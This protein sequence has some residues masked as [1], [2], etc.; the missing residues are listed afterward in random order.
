MGAG[1]KSLL[2]RGIMNL[3]RTLTALGLVMVIAGGNEA[4]NSS[5]RKKHHHIHGKITAV[6]Q[7]K[8]GNGSITIVVHHHK[9]KGTAGVNAGAQTTEKK[10]HITNTTKLGKVIHAGKGQNKKESASFSDLH[11]GQHVLVV[12]GSGKHHGAKAVAIVVRANG[13]KKVQ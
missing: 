9:K 6:H 7:G 5:I 11:E 10:I 2:L 3:F 12:P 13:K 4:A 1:T 8:D